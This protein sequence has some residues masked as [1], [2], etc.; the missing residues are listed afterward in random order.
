VAAAELRRL[1][2]ELAAAPSAA[3]YGRC[4]TTMQAFGTATSWLVDVLNVLTGNLDRPGGAMFAAPATGGP[5]FSGEPGRGPGVRLGRWRS[6][7]RGLPETLG[8]LPL[9]VL[10]EEIEAGAIRALVTFSGNPVLTNPN[11]RRLDAALARLD[12]F[13]ALDPYLNETTRRAHVVLP[14]PSPLE[15]SHYPVVVYPTALRNVANYSPPVLERPSGMPDEWETIL[16]LTA[17]VSGRGHDADLEALDREVALDTLRRRVADPRSPVA[18][19]DPEELLQALEPRTGPERLL[20]LMLRLGPYGDAFGAR[21]GGITLAVLEANPHG[22]DLGPLEPRLP[23]ALRTPSGKVELAHPVLLAEGERLERALAE[24]P[25]PLVL[26]GRRE[27]RSLNSWLHNLPP[28]VRGRERCT[29]LVHP[30]DA[31]RLG[32]ADGRRARVASRTGAIEL[33][34]EVTDAIMP[35]VVSI[36]H[37]FGHGLPGTRQRVAAQHAGVSMNDVTDEQLVDAVTGTAILNGVPVEVS[38]CG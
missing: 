5:T 23:A 24:E 13:V 7:V 4:G 38:S 21:P 6:S 36:P 27:Y 10:A 18:G 25:P 33:P 2:R 28:L 14:P 12:C 17:I 37:G 1:A 31:E 30:A 20:D 15:R 16:R 34:V 26:I 32:L 29:L 11:G 8:E 9:A 19:R 3:V 35:G 22:V